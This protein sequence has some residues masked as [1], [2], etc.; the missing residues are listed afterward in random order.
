M[1]VTYATDSL[2]DVHKKKVAKYQ[3][4][5][6]MEAFQR[7]LG[8]YRET[9]GDW[10]LTDF[11]DAGANWRETSTLKCDC[12]KKLRYQYTVTNQLTAEKHNFG[13]DHLK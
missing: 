2:A 10:N 4:K 11:Q 6:K 1:D 3:K 12:G 9:I 5:K 7:A 13:I 8:E